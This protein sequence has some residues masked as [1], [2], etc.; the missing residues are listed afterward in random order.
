MNNLEDISR[1]SATWFRASRFRTLTKYTTDPQQQEAHLLSQVLNYQIDRFEKKLLHLDGWML[2]EMYLIQESTRALCQTS[3][4]VHTTRFRRA[5]L[6]TME[7]TGYRVRGVAFASALSALP[8]D[9]CACADMFI[10]HCLSA[11][12]PS[13][14][15][16]LKSVSLKGANQIGPV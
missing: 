7:H 9:S 6:A 1:A 13:S 2:T 12:R 14:P 8:M 4:A 16:C 10:A 5:K 15:G 3:S 11:P